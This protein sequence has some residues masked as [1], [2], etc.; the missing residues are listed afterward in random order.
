MA[1]A[2]ARR[3]RGGKPFLTLDCETDPFKV[4]RIPVPFIWGIY[5]HDTEDYWEFSTPQ[6]VVEFLAPQKVIVYAHN[7]G[8][9]DY[10]YLRDDI[11]SDDPMMV[12]A[13]RLARFKIGEC[14]FRDSWN[15][16]NEPLRVFQKEDFD[17]TKL[18]A[19]NRQEF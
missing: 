4:G 8:K 17:Y 5:R 15:V 3:R 12:I 6:E 1:G 14:E 19:D 7:G 10:H 9:F 16:L 2:R 11:N 13:G 18:E